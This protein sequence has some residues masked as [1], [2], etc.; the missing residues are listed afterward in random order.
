MFFFFE[1]TWRKVTVP[2]FD[3]DSMKIFTELH[4]KETVR[5]VGDTELSR[6][7]SMGG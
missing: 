2:F 3:E 5:A 7:G 4:V 6:D 1:E